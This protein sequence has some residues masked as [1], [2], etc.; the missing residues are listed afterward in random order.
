M[1]V[2]EGRKRIPKATAYNIVDKIVVDRPER[3]CAE[4]QSMHTA[5]AVQVRADLRVSFIQSL[6]CL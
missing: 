4:Y 2:W 6:V 1:G 3:Q 5:H